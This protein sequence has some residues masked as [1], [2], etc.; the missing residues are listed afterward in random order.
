VRRTL[1]G[2]GDHARPVLIINPATDASFA[3]LAETELAVDGHDREA[4]QARLRRRYPQTVV[5]ARELSG[6]QTTIWYV[7]RDGHWTRS[8][9]RHDDR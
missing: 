9:R 4:F 3:A 5:H 1:L 7:Y 8:E 2:M 6:E